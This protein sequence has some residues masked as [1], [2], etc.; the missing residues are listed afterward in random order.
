MPDRNLTAAEQDSVALPLRMTG[1]LSAGVRTG[2]AACF[3]GVA[4]LCI[5]ATAAVS[6]A[7]PQFNW[8]MLA[9][10][11]IVHA[12]T[13]VVPANVHAVTYADAARFAAGRGLGQRMTKLQEGDYREVVAAGD[14]ATFY[15]QLPF[16]TESGRCIFWSSREWPNSRPRSPRRLSSYRPCH[17]PSADWEFYGTRF[18]RSGSCPEA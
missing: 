4:I 11:A 10:V 17:M 8:D 5:V 14:A 12:W 3:V 9:Y 6:W 7:K 2:I 16:F 13:D 15:E 1:S 18:G